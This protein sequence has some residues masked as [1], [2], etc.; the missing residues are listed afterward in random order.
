MR[1]LAGID[2]GVKRIGLALADGL[3]LI[4][5][6]VD[7]LVGVADVHRDAEAV[8]RWAVPHEVAG[9]VVGLPLSLDGGDSAQTK[10]TRAFAR[11][12][13]EHS[14]MTIELWDERL[15]SYQA[16]LL[17]QSASMKRT[18]RKRARDAIAAQ[19]ILQAY[20]D[21][22]RPPDSLNPSLP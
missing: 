6:P 13:E 9:F 1:I 14:G 21:A 22:H 18:Q 19:V 20:L 12:L 10:L 16:D 3:G 4:A 17:M 15:S 7:V 11:A 5:S 2:Y 8:T